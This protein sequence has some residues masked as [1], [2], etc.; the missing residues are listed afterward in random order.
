MEL[1]VED[2]SD[3]GEPGAR[4]VSELRD[5]RLA[6]HHASEP[7][8]VIENFDRA[9]ARARGEYVA[10]VGDDDGIGAEVMKATRWARDNSLDAV[11]PTTPARYVWPDLR[12][13]GREALAAGELR[14]Y[15][16]SGERAFPDPEA[17][18]LACARSAGQS[19]G[20]LPKAYYGIVR[21]ECMERVREQTGSFFPG[22]SPDMAA[23]IGLATKVKR[24]CWI[25][26][27]LFVPGSSRQSTAGE[28][29]LGLHVGRLSEQKHLPANCEDRWSSVV[30]RFF[31]VQT[32]WAEA[33][34][35]ALHATKREDILREFDVAALYAYCAMFHTRY[36]KA[37]ASQFLPALAATG[38]NRW[39]GA[40]EFIDRMAD[41]V[42]MRARSLARRLRPPAPLNPDHLSG[43]PDI[44]SAVSAFN[45][46]MVATRNK[47]PS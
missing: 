11:V 4:L 33:L 34:V 31:S 41:L 1:V 37:T 8:S 47:F 43:L 15:P 17:E 5:E 38:R 7:V 45:L 28:S 36:L 23:A 18:L 32:I 46:Y 26:Y 12:M 44:G 21:R 24:Y 19:F 30:P 27:P 40:R 25:D 42:R 10:F 9:L 22:V 13:S 2:N 35:E 14:I 3:S 16:F 29:G 39:G 6:Y 20:R